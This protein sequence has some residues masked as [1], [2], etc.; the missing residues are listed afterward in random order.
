[1]LTATFNFFII[2]T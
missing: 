2:Q 1:M